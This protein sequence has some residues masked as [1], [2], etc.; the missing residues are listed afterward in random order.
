[1]RGCTGIH[2]RNNQVKEYMTLNLVSS[3]KG[4]HSPDAP[5]PAFSGHG[6]FEAPAE[7]KD[8]VPAVNLEKIDHHLA[9]INFLK[10]SGLKGSRVIRAY[11]WRSLTHI[12]NHQL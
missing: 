2:L 7:W 9:A 8:D 6:I 3:K 12:F 4:W 11:Y 5:L 10:V 1:V